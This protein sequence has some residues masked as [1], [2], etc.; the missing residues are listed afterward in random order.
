MFELINN[1][2]VDEMQAN[3]ILQAKS[4]RFSPQPLPYTDRKSKQHALTE[5][6]SRNYD[7]HYDKEPP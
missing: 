6:Y 2:T 4:S 1:L 7:D 5:I 3:A